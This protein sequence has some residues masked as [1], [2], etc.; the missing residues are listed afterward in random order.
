MSK[1]TKPTVFACFS[2]PIMLA[3]F[4]IEIGLA[5]YLLYSR[6]LNKTVLLAILLL[7]SLAT[8]QLSEY[9]ICEDVGFSA[10]NWGRLGFSSITLLPPLGLH[11]VYKLSRKKSRVLVTLS[12]AL[13]LVWVMLFSFG[14][15]MERAVCEGNYVIF[16]IS[17]P[18]EFI[19]YVYYNLFIAIAVVK[20]WSFYKS[21]T[22]KR[23]KTA[24]AFLLLGYMSFIVPSIIV[25]LIFDFND[26]HNSAL[27]SIMCG[28]AVILAVITALKVA[29]NDSKS[30]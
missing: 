9:G 7:V 1:L 25:R 27:P 4:V 10:T 6:K 26:A 14:G 8:F 13:A 23:T 24:L 22:A 5:S 20:G 29:P 18:A 17:D 19:Y 21:M 11:L 2:P 30:K 12:Y 15:I 28:F 3:T 16:H